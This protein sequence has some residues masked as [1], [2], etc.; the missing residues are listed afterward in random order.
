MS[1]VRTGD[2][3]RRE[4][5]V[6]RSLRWSW[7]RARTLESCPR[8][9]WSQ[10]IGSAGGARADAEASTRELWIQKRLHQSP[11]WIGIAVHSLA[12]WVINEASKGRIV[13]PR[14]ARSRIRWRM[15]REREASALGTYRTASGR[16]VGLSEHY[17]GD[18]DADDIHHAAIDEAARQ[19]EQMFT[20]PVFA[21]VLERIDRVV[22]VEQLRRVTLAG[23]PCWVALDA[24]VRLPGQS[25]T[26]VDWKTGKNHDDEMVDRQLTVY[27]LYVREAYGIT[28]QEAIA[29]IHADLRGNTFRTVWPDGEQF[30]RA[31]AEIRSSFKQM[32][33]VEASFRADPDVDGWFP[34]LEVGAAACGHCRFRGACRRT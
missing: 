4:V 2:T 9:Y 33:E 21:R 26:V 31:S 3:G 17:Y 22:E 13:T 30:D 32:S 8:K 27:G 25:C 5:C 20:H 16:V 19:V 29:V 10:Y 6:G 12:E 28:S 23:V 24:V 11:A 7:S 15:A 18:S 1:Q 34:Q 14:E